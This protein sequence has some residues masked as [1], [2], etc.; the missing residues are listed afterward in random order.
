MHAQQDYPRVTAVLDVIADWLKHRRT[1]GHNLDGLP[2][3]EVQRIAH[4][5]GL[6]S[7]DL[8]AL[9]RLADQP[10]LLPQMLSAL[11][12]DPDALSRKEPLM[13]RDLQ[14]VCAMCDSKKR[15]SRD[16]GE[17]TAGVN[18]EDYCPNSLTLKSMS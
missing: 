12:I 14:R 6:S 13:F 3:S 16:L 2:D 5:M 15:C 18:F 17:G 8:R 4:D 7:A 1:H 9:D 10:L 11:H